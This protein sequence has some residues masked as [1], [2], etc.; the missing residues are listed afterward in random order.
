MKNKVEFMNTQPTHTIKSVATN[1]EIGL[2]SKVAGN[3]VKKEEQH[4]FL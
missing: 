3:S 1:D 4:S 2:E